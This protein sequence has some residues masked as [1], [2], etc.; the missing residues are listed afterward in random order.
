LAA[1]ATVIGDSHLI[2]RLQKPD[3]TLFAA[4]ARCR[5][6]LRLCLR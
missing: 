3:D 2:L 4:A 5:R 6:V 1:V